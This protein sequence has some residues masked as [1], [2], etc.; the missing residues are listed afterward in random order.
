[1]SDSI[2]VIINKLSPKFMRPVESRSRSGVALHEYKSIAFDTRTY[3]FGVLPLR[4]SGSGLPG[5]QETVETVMLSFIMIKYV[6]IKIG[7][8]I[9][10]T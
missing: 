1:M 8:S 10:C 9:T 4:G 5:R 6:Q 3:V 2:T 7:I